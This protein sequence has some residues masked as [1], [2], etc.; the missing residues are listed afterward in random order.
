VNTKISEE[1]TGSILGLKMDGK[2]GT[3]SS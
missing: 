2:E 3:Y 1:Y